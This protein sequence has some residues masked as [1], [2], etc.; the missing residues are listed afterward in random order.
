M[1]SEF[2]NWY[3][4][5]FNQLDNDP[6]SNT[7]ENISNELDIQEVWTNVHFEL[8]KKSRVRLL[9]RN[10]SY[11]TG[12]LILFGSG[13]LF[14][15]YQTNAIRNIPL[16]KYPW[17][18]SHNDDKNITLF[19][20]TITSKYP[21]EKIKLVTVNIASKYLNKE[22]KKFKNRKLILTE[23]NSELA[24]K[25][26]SIHIQ[27]EIKRDVTDSTNNSKD[28]SPT[29]FAV[30]PIRVYLPEKK[31]SVAN[32]MELFC[33]PNE[34]YSKS[35]IIGTAFT[36][37][38]SWLFNNDTY[39][40][41]NKNNLNQTNLSFGNSYAVLLGYDLSNNYTIQSEWSINNKQEQD[42]VRY[43]EGK[44]V[45]KKIIINYTYFDL[46]IKKKEA[47]FAFKNRIPASFNYLAGIQYSY[48]KSISRTING[49]TR[50]V[51]NRYR[52]DNYGLVLGVEYQLTIKHL[53]IISSGLRADIGMRNIYAGNSV[54]P[55]SFNRTYNSSI[56]LNVGINY[57]IPIKRKK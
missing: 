55:A 11:L 22:Q 13:M 29:M 34:G 1:K 50:S 17:N 41:F 7:W 21:S 49:N 53:W 8:Q 28:I 19:N 56:G 51:K 23:I 10:L 39:D 42:Y 57:V 5:K 33:L 38:N 37:S 9:K 54:T 2:S 52:K 20:S 32:S 12:V 18:Y 4:T 25:N 36:Y 26:S 46:L 3:R 24:E 27:N 15:Y 16:A 43:I 40:G 14:F 48:I 31:N 44:Q 47:R 6:P 35:L 30:L 45:H